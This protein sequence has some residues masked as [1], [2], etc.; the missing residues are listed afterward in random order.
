MNI[1]NTKTKRLYLTAVLAVIGV[2]LV[3]AG[4][5]TNLGGIVSLGVAISAGT[6]GLILGWES[7]LLEDCEP[8]KK[9]IKRFVDEEVGPV[10][11]LID[12]GILNGEYT[13][14]SGYGI[15]DD[16][17][18]YCARKNKFGWDRVLGVYKSIDGW[19]ISTEKWDVLEKNVVLRVDRRVVPSHLLDTR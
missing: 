15:N 9:N 19:M 6:F 7:P 10:Q 13:L 12:D 11:K 17:I 16:H 2:I 14:N 5:L 4:A 18:V 3:I 8:N 1:M